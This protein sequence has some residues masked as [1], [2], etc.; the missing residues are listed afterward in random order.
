MDEVETIDEGGFTV[1]RYRGVYIYEYEDGGFFVDS[2]AAPDF[3]T[4][5]DAVA[6]IDKMEIHDGS[7]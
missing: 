3:E 2:D 1:Y 6:F 4:V 7:A 5:N